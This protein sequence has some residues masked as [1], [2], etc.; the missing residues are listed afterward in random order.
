MQQDP[1]VRFGAGKSFDFTPPSG[2]AFLFWIISLL[3]IGTGLLVSFIA[4]INDDFIGAAM[5]GVFVIPGCILGMILTPT[6]LQEEYNKIRI[7]EKPRDYI[8][9][10]EEGG[11]T[12]SFWNGSYS[13]SPKKDDR[14]WVFQSPGPE[15]WDKEDRYGPDDT[16]IISEHPTIIGTPIPASFS[17]DG[18]LICIMAL[19]SIPI[20]MLS[21]YAGVGILETGSDTENSTFLACALI[22]GPA[23]ASIA[24]AFIMWR[25][26]TKMQL[27]IDI[28]TSKVRSM[29]AGE[30]ELVGQVRRSSTPAPPVQVGND[31]GR[32]CDDLHA[33]EWKYE[34]YV[35]RYTVEMTDKGPRPKTEYKW[36]TIEIKE[37]GYDFILHDGTGG[38]LVKPDT[39]KHKN[40]GDYLR[41]WEIDHNRNLG[42]IF[43]SLITT[44][45]GGWTILKHKWT[46][47]GIALGDPCYIL[48]TAKSRPKESNDSLT[49]YQQTL[50]QVV[51]ESGVGFEA[52]LERGTELGVLGKVKSQVEYKIIPGILAAGCIIGTYLAYANY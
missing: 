48:G 7:K 4:L 8:Q 47:W 29:A 46:L 28:P 2:A 41:M 20:T 34:I 26:G 6:R 24:Y 5:G 23:I 35:K 11:L 44:T 45:F 16:G 39:F 50:M 38:T 37:G 3:I 15:Y 25:T 43:G 32:T 22:F 31:P 10:S 13:S 21:V 12:G 9:R 40:L 51:G 30:L 1:K 42:E 52:R 19:Y 27:T 49:N 33:W 18:V 36:E 17:L 14:G